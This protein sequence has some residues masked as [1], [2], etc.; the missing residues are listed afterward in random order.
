MNLIYHEREG[1]YNAEN[2]S[3][4]IGTEAYATNIAVVATDEYNNPVIQWTF[5][6]AF[7]VEIPNIELNYQK[8]DEINCS[9]SFYFSQMFVK[10]FSLN[11]EK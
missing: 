8:T 2:I 7:P 5:T 10:N 3:N 11:P 4:K 9:C 1:R 6:K